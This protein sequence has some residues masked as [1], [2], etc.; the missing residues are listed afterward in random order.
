[1]QYK[2]IGSGNSERAYTFISTKFITIYSNY[3]IYILITFKRFDPLKIEDC[4]P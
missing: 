3:N 4:P 1:M 2:S